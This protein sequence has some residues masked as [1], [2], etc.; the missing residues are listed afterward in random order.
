MEPD[1]GVFAEWRVA[2]RQA[3]RLE[4]ALSR[5][6]LRALQGDGPSP[7]SEERQQANEL[8]SKADGLFD[9]AMAELAARA[10]RLRR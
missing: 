5:A 6:A 10:E 2:D 3:H 1:V 8:R 4:Q 7:T 9:L